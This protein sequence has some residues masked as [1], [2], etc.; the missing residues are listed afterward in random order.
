[1]QSIYTGLIYIALGII[2]KIFPNLLAGYNQLS[3][4]ERENAKMNGLPTFAF[5][6]FIIMGALVIAGHFVAIWMDKPSLSSSI[7]MS[8]TLIGIVVMV[9]SGR[10]FTN[11]PVR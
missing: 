10:R 3:Q 8:V 2:I 4:R 5:I 11:D 6:V 9:V 1:M 7:F